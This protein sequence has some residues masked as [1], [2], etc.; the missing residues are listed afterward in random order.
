MA[1]NKGSQ[2]P[3]SAD[4]T[5]NAGIELDAVQACANANY[6]TLLGRLATSGA[7]TP[8]E[9]WAALSTVAAGTRPRCLPERAA[10]TLCTRPQQPHRRLLAT[11]DLGDAE[12]LA[13]LLGDLLPRLSG[14]D[15]RS[16]FRQLAA[17]GEIQP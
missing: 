4:A 11:L 8:E 1:I 10:N 16:P 2:T 7:L 5:R 3:R 6:M 17:V 9:V 12:A 14:L 13:Q 15:E